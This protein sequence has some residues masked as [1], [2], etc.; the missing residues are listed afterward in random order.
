MLTLEV[1]H[2]LPTSYPQA[3]FDWLLIGVGL[4]FV[5][6][7]AIGIYVVRKSK[8][9]FPTK[10]EINRLA[11]EVVELSGE[12]ADLRD[13][14]SRFQKREGLRVA[15]EEKKSQADLMAEAAAITAQAEPV[16]GGS[17]SSKV[18]LYKRL[19]GH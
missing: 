7:I 2:M 5:A 11:G 19:R 1:I 10:T 17:R 4:E 3:I 12:Q 18:D 14:F 9:D 13:R 6:L 8:R 16:A 15:R